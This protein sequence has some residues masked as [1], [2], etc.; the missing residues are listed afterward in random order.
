MLRLLIVLLFS[1]LLSGCGFKGDLYLPPTDP[2][3]DKAYTGF[4]N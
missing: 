4:S 1:V 3:S 2:A